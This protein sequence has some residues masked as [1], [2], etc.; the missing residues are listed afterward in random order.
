MLIFNILD[1]SHNFHAQKYNKNA[2]RTKITRINAIKIRIISIKNA[3]SKTM[4]TLGFSTIAG[5]KDAI[6]KGLQNKIY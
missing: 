6:K 1:L 4:A 3:M 5:I 2:K